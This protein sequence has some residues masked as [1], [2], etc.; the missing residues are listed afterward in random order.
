MKALSTTPVLS[1]VPQQEPARAIEY[2]VVFPDPCDLAKRINTKGGGYPSLRDA[3]LAA[4]PEGS[5]RP[6]YEGRVERLYRDVKRALRSPTRS[7]PKEHWA[8]LG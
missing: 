1:I 5:K 7:V 3:F 6:E 8:L 2:E 4:L